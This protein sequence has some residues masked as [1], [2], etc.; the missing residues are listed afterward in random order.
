MDM[1]YTIVTSYITK[2]TMVSIMNDI[3]MS[4]ILNN[5]IVRVFLK[6]FREKF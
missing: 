6:D 1:S 5:A 4:A 3:A 2:V